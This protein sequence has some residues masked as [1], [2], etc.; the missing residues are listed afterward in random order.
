[1]AFPAVIFMKLQMFTSI[2]CR[3]VKPGFTQ[4]QHTNVESMDKNSF[5][6]KIKYGFHCAYYHETHSHSVHVCG[7]LLYQTLSTSDKKCKR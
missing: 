3:S 4:I 6:H 1:M 7:H 5:M 2:M